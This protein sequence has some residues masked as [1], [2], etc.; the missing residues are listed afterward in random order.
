MIDQPTLRTLAARFRTGLERF[1]VRRPDVNLSTNFLNPTRGRFPL[2]CCKA[3][4]FMFGE[5]LS[6]TEGA[7]DLRYVW[8]CGRAETHGW[9]EYRNLIV[10]ITPDQFPDQHERIIVA[11]VGTS[12]WHSTFANQQSTLFSLKRSHPFV[13]Y[14][15]E[16]IAEL[17]NDEVPRDR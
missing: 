1:L 4:S 12:P 13:R 16:V 7:E 6:L 10:D 8:G 11:P 3:S 2:D 5:Y 15:R 9:L 17:A 14:T